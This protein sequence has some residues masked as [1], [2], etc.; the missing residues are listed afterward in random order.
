MQALGT[1]TNWTHLLL[2]LAQFDNVDPIYTKPRY[3]NYC[4]KS[5]RAVK[6]TLL[7]T[8]SHELLTWF[9]IVWLF[10]TSGVS[11]F[12]RGVVIT[13]LL[14][15]RCFNSLFYFPFHLHARIQVLTDT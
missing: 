10:Q 15:A 8:Y 5:G 2:L 1:I 6:F 14:G 11:N 3:S 9:E 4:N 12:H 7:S 13:L